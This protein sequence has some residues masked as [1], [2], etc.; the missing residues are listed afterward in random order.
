MSGNLDWNSSSQTNMFLFIQKIQVEF[1]TIFHFSTFHVSGYH[2]SLLC[3]QTSNCSCSGHS[4]P[5]LSPSSIGLFGI[6]LNSSCCSHIFGHPEFLDFYKGLAGKILV[7]DRV[8][9]VFVFSFVQV[10]KQHFSFLGFFW[11]H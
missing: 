5:I 9:I 10:C 1:K 3:A 7:K 4:I 11:L 2:K 6:V 8:K